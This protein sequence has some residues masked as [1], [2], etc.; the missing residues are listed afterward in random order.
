RNKREITK[1]L[2]PVAPGRWWMNG[3]MNRRLSER[4]GWD[5]IMCSG[6]TGEERPLHS[7]EG[8]KAWQGLSDL[9][10]LIALIIVIFARCTA[11]F[12][13]ALKFFPTS[14]RAS[15]LVVAL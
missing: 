7:D 8:V 14:G 5:G 2:V 12:R 15:F 10:V 1:A 9:S 4:A 13:I 3:R 11:L 6:W